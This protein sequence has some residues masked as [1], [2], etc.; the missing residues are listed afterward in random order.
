MAKV[1]ISELTAKGSSLAQ[2]DLIPIA[3]V[4]GGGYV[5][6]RVN[7]N[8]VNFRVFTQT[9]NS[10]TITNTTTEST[11]IGTGVGSLLIPANGFAVGDS[12]H[13]K[14]IGHISCNSSATIR[15]R[16]KSGSVLLAETGIIALDTAT[17]KHWELN[18]YFTIR[19]L[20]AT[21]V[22]SIASGGIFS[23]TKNSGLNFE[24]TNFSE[25]NNTT[26]DTTISNTLNITAQWGAA[27]AAD[28]IYSEIFTLS[29][30]Y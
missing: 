12:F 20:G 30:T 3:E 19:A 4:L 28:S 18:V 14:L 21:T 10:T 1:K 11:L 16:V 25:V 5:T 26:F 6:K 29:K 13:A 23:Y 8:N 22:A 9:A 2:T 15:L 24:G 27:N 17:N 7:G